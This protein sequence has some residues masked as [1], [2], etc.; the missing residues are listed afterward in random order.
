LF[1]KKLG[2]Q[3]SDIQGFIKKIGSSDVPNPA[4]LAALE[5]YRQ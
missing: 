4:L 1:S 3:L 5:R 2:G